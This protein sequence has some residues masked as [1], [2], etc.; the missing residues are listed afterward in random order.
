M[1]RIFSDFGGLIFAG[2]LLAMLILPRKDEDDREDSPSDEEGSA[3][4][5]SS[6]ISSGVTK[7]QS[8][9]LQSSLDDEP[10]LPNT[11]R[12]AQKISKGSESKNSRKNASPGKKSIANA[13]S[14]R[15]PSNSR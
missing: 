9:P 3:A 2:G 14:S 10:L 7:E 4:E 5:D 11:V 15:S 8:Q 1:P 13:K 6:T 12:V